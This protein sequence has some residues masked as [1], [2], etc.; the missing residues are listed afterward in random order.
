MIVAD[1]SA[2]VELLLAAPCSGSIRGALSAHN[3]LHV[4]EHFH[5]E[6]LSVLR[7]RSLRRE[8]D[9]L[10][11]VESLTALRELRTVTYP[12]IELM[13]EIWSMRAQLTAYDAAYLALAQRL[14]VG[15]ITI[16]AGLAKAAADDGR[17]VALTG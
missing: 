15:L 11:A 8:M 5:V 16:D 14:D 4:P 7:R 1:A 3:E 12:V 10:R 9:E 17:L 13:E 6:V 2:V